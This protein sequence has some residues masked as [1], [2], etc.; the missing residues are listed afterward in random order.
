MRET[1]IRVAQSSD[2]ERL[3]EVARRSWLSAFAQ[4]APFSMIERWV[5][6][7]RE[8][9]WYP[10]Y[11]SSMLV[12]VVEGV[13]V[14]VVQPN[15]DEVNGL[16]VHPDYQH[17]G[18]GSV[19]LRAGED[20]ILASGYDWAWLTCSGFNA[21]ALRFY[22]ARGYTELRRFRELL[23][24]GLEEENIVLGRRLSKPS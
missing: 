8:L 4:T 18:H 1:R 23:P 13:V 7:N 10:A 2:V 20:A 15:Q 3:V 21:N 19:L 9:E 5:R 14:G 12:A 11:W 17:K 24:C 16:W 22:R 6:A